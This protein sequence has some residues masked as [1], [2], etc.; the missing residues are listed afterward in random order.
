MR[1]GVLGSGIVGRTLGAGFIKHGHQVKLGTRDPLDEEVRNWITANPGATA[2]TFAE[3]AAYG[4]MLLLAAKGSIVDKVIELSKPENFSGKTVIDANN[5]IA[6]GPPVQG[7]LPFTT[8]PNESLGEKIQAMIPKAHVVKAF[9][10]VGSALMVNP[11]FEQGTP[12]MFLCGDDEGAKA[13]VSRIIQQLGWE[14]V[15]CGGIIAS[16]AIEPLCMLWLI[17]G[18]LRNQ[19]THAFKL[20]TQ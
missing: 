6:D 19:W 8:G 17:P 7:V 10:S 20:L 2:G 4:E 13:Q 11:H 3:A 9:N 5:P 18:F 1:I 15:D 14:P 12:S 16:R